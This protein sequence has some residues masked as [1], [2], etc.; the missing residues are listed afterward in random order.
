MYVTMSIAFCLLI[1]ASNI[2]G[3]FNARPLGHEP[4]YKL[5]PGSNV[6]PFSHP[7]APVT[8][9]AAFAT[10]H[11]WVTPFQPEERFPSGDYPN[12]HTGG[13]G[14]PAWTKADRPIENTDVV[15]WYTLGSHHITRPEDWPVMPA[16]RAGFMLKPAACSTTTRRSMSH[17]ARPRTANCLERARSW[18]GRRG[19]PMMVK[20]ISVPD[21]T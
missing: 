2:T 8:Q 1:A 14:L 7:D 13:A 20:R 16:D 21:L 17:R 4:A 18:S 5:V 10:K 9:R 19:Q 11:L 12:Q 6:L 15:L 3:L